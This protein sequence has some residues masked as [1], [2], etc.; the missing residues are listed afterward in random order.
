MTSQTFASTL[1]LLLLRWLARNYDH[2]FLLCANCASDTPLTPEEAQLWALLS[3]L[4]DDNE[5]GA[6]ACRLRLSLA[7]RCCPE[8]VCPWQVGEQLLLYL[9]KLDFVPPSCRLCATDELALLRMHAMHPSVAR[10]A[11]YV[12]A[13]LASSDAHQIALPPAMA[14]RLGRAAPL[15]E[16]M[17][18]SLLLQPQCAGLYRRL[19]GVKYTRPD[20]G[21]GA[22]EAVGVAAIKII[23]G[24]LSA[25]PKIDDSKGFWLQ[26]ELLT[27]GL[28]LKILAD[29]QP[30]GLGSL[31]FRLC[32]HQ[33]AMELVPLLRTMEAEPNLAAEMPKYQGTTGR[34]GVV[35]ALG[36]KGS[37]QGQGG[38]RH[39]R[40]DPRP[41]PA[42]DPDAASAGAARVARLPARRRRAGR[43]AAE[44]ARA[45]PEAPD[46]ADAGGPHV[47]P[48]GALDA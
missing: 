43:R 5:P 16:G 30:H 37:L 26:Y 1:Y 28:S 33:S 23:N 14:T 20:L 2:A 44:P 8:L 36:N 35:G 42:R 21:K 46:E 19:E 47:R 18:Y 29:D 17:Y 31:L 3:D 13:S 38:R 6:H 39:R 24:L 48:R 4:D 7:T 9:S 41:P 40:R 27:N 11:A 32:N 12:E 25:A 34:K 15:D 45:A 10:R 22:E